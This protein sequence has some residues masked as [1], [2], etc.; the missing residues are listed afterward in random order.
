[1][2]LSFAQKTIA[3]FSTANIDSPYN[4]GFVFTRRGRGEMEQTRSVRVDLGKFEL[5]S[6]NRRVLRKTENLKLK[7]VALPHLSYNWKI[8]KLGHDFYTKKF[9]GKTFSANKIKELL[10]DE[11]K[12]NFNLL[13]EY[14]TDEPIGYAICLQTENILH[15]SYPFYNLDAK[16]PNLGMAMMIKAICYAKEQGKKYIYLGSA[17]ASTA[18]YKFQFI[19]VEWFD[20]KKWNNDIEEL[21]NVLA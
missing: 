8:H 20:G 17:G 1:M 10:T 18:L 9:G 11:S 15:Y 21:K 13:L 14:C 16:L 4:D 2:Y 19:G 3:N 7:T 6:E 5:T 12:S